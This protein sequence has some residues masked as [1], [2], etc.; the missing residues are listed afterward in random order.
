MNK[1]KIN[2]EKDTLENRNYRKVI[3]TTKDM[4][5]VLMSLNP[6]EEIGLEKHDGSQFIR[7]EKGNGIAYISGKRYILKDGVAIV[8]P[9]N[10]LHNIISGDNG[11]KLYS[12]YTPP[13]HK[14]D[15]IQKIKPNLD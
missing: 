10:H 13:Q 14:K 2:I 12:I 5:V 8:I 4:Q 9:S 1:Y 15:T 6:F 3:S 11:L 7:V